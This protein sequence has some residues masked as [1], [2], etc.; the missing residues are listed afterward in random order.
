MLTAAGNGFCQASKAKPAPVKVS[1][2]RLIPFPKQVKSLPGSF[3]VSSGMTIT[4]SDSPAARQALTDLQLELASA[5]KVKTGF[6]LVPAGKNLYTLT[7]TTA[8]SPRTIVSVPLPKEIVS[9]KEGYRIWM[10]PDTV[11]V[12]SATDSGLVCG[13]QTLRQLVRANMR[14]SSIPCLQI[15]DWPSLQYRG[16]QD[17]ITRGASPSYKTLQMEVASSSLLKMNV[18]T[19][20]IEHQYKFAKHPLI[21]P[22]D[23]SLTPQ[24]LKLLVQYAKKFNVEIIGCQQSF[25]HFATILQ[26]D[27]YKPLSEN[28]WI[29]DPT[30]EDSYKLLD[31]MYSEQAPLTESK[32]FNVCC[33][34]TDGLGTGPSKPLADKIGVGGVYSM[35]MK[36]IHDMLRDKYGKRMMMWGDIILR[37]PDHLKEI[38]KDTLMLSWGYEALPSFENDIMPFANSGYDF[39]VCPGVNCWSRILPHFDKAV[40]NIRNFVRDGAKHGALGMLNTTWDDD[41]ENLFNYNW[42]GIAWGAE[43]A[44]NASVTNPADFNRRIGAV[45]F[46]EKGNHFGQAIDLLSKTHTLLGYEAMMD[47]RFWR[48]D[49]GHL[50]VNK[51]SARAQAKALLEIVEPAIQHLQAA[52]KDARV[53]ADLLDYFIF[54]AERMKLMA[55][56]QIDFLAAAK[57]YEAAWYNANDKDK[58]ERLAVRAKDA[59]KVIRMQHAS[60]KYRYIA[61]WNRENKPYALDRATGRFDTMIKRYDDILDAMT[62]SIDKLKKDGVLLSPKEIGLDVV[63]QGVRSTK[64]EKRTGDESSAAA[65]W[66]N[67][68]FKSRIGITV[69]SSD[70]ARLDQ[71]IEL[72]IPLKAGIPDFFKLYEV[73]STSGKQTSVP[74]QTGKGDGGRRIYFIVKGD[75]PAKIS[76]SFLLYFDPDA[77]VADVSATRGVS[78]K[79]GK[80]SFVWV[81]NDQIRLLL[82]AE[83]AHI[84]RWEIKAL[85]NLDITHPGET[86]W[87]GFADNFMPYRN[88]PNKMEVLANGDVLVRVKCTDST[89]MEKTFSVW[90]GVPWVEVTYNAPCNWISC[91]DDISIMGARSRTPGTFLFSDGFTGQIKPDGVST[92]SQVARDNTYWSAKYVPDGV[93]LALVTPEVQARHASGPGGGMGGVMLEGG[94]ASAHFVI[95]GSKCPGSVA[96]TLNKV[97]ASLD[98]RNQPAVTIS[99]VS[100]RK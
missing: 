38:P 86:D 36:R 65:P 78:L 22:K 64:A 88:L 59:I 75:M 97:Q 56:R 66:E 25:G 91:Y 83:G 63:E 20:Y 79:N 12:S 40:V 2:L 10:S 15:I 81:E 31:D 71:P 54:G 18:F 94:P 28:P 19:Y 95:Y 70:A 14:G 6:K 42:H 27:K 76:R 87:S 50:P 61:L 57:I 30:N 74:C 99:G 1:D 100:N 52:K 51:E 43:C 80:D 82:G 32:F 16:F 90:A 96:E 29:L 48:F 4:V 62:Q 53:N 93:L 8:K 68:A 72:D 34:E 7:I 85:D 77:S 44:W 89:G 39:F 67:A 3:A 84:Y 55:T 98:L 92:T 73:D 35:H 47:S 13:I 26:H 21:G 37:H 24:E 45:M 9:Q 17:D 46:G 33:D 41:G 23:G 11:T 58:A 5:A 60:M 49:D 69:G